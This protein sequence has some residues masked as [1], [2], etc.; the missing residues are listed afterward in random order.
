MTHQFANYPSLSG[1]A[2]LVSGGATGIGAEIVG[3]FAQQG[4]K[5]AFLDFDRDAGNAL[6]DD[7]GVAFEYC[8]LRDIQALRAGVSA[9]RE[10]VGPF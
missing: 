3:A 2:V 5:V 9:L 6:A 8:D 1:R 10:R 4:A 7:L